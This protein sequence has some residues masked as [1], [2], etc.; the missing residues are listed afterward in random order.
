[1]NIMRGQAKG[2]MTVMED[3]E[4]AAHVGLFSWMVCEGVS[5]AVG[6]RGGSVSRGCG[7]ARPG[8]KPDEGFRAC[9]RRGGDLIRRAGRGGR[10][11][12][13]ELLGVC[14]RTDGVTEVGADGCRRRRRQGSEWYFEYS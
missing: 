10:G 8:R 1:M 13:Y 2:K 5:G 3:E 9:W 6:R 7:R 14:G 12:G 11:G 4:R